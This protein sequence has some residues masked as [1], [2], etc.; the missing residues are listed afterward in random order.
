MSFL[1][2]SANFFGD[3]DVTWGD[4]GLQL[5]TGGMSTSAVASRVEARRAEQQQREAEERVRQE[6]ARR[7]QY[8]SRIRDLFGVGTGADS[9]TNSA[10]L[11]QMLDQFYRDALETNLSGVNKGYSGASRVSRQNLARAGQLGSSLDAS[12]RG[13]NLAEFLRQ[14][15]ASVQRAAQQKSDLASSLASLRTGLEGQVSSGSLTNPDFTSLANQQLSLVEQARSNLVPQAVG[16]A[17]RQAGD[18]YFN[19]RVQEAQGNRGLQ[20]FGMG[21]GSGRSGSYS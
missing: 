2:K 3:K 19:G 12:T 9:E 13:G 5:L 10:R 1:K 14:R 7:D 15:Q 6:Q 21:G 8:I 17:F 20:V 11:S 16:N 4:V 18:T